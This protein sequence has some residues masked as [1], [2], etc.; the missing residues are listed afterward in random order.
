MRN[1]NS[2]SKIT[3]SRSIYIAELGSSNTIE[4]E[5]IRL[6]TSSLMTN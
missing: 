4:I 6:Y 5:Y 1:F 2:A 3:E